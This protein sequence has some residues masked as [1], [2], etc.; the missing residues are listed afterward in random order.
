MWALSYNKYA[1]SIENNLLIQINDWFEK[2]E[3]LL[4]NFHRDYLHLDFH[5]FGTLAF[6]IESLKK[7]YS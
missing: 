2:I 7:N 6:L 1:N 5:F 4:Y 3:Q